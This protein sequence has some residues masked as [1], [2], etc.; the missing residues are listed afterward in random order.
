MIA[1]RRLRR[2][3]FLFVLSDDQCS[4]ISR[5]D[6]EQAF[7]LWIRSVL[8]SLHDSPFLRLL[9]LWLIFFPRQNCNL[10]HSTSSSNI[11]KAD[12]SMINLFSLLNPLS[13]PQSNS[14]IYILASFL[15]LLL[16]RINYNISLKIKSKSNERE[17][18]C[19]LW[20]DH[21]LWVS[22]KRVHLQ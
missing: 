14:T 21:I 10:W 8:L 19:L 11:S 7:S 12:F 9:L 22:S 18:V 4:F 13:S 1:R 15:T 20:L 17:S 3:L 5:P 16:L 6:F 2:L